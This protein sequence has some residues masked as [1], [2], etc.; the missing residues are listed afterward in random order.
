MD[1][2]RFATPVH[3][4]VGFGL[5]STIESVLESYELLD[6]WPPSQRRSEHK[7]A[8]KACRAALNGEIDPETARSTFVEF[9][10]RND[11]LAPS[12]EHAFAHRTNGNNRGGRVIR[13]MPR[14]AAGADLQPS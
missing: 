7:V 14:G 11:L 9:A 12:E 3:V 4:I 13:P 10:R 8:L 1:A 2:L 5:P 6:D